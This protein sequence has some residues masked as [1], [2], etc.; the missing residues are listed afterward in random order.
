MKATAKCKG[1]IPSAKI[2]VG[3][4][5]YIVLIDFM[6]NKARVWLFRLKSN[7]LIIGS[8]KFESFGYEAISNENSP[9]VITFC[10]SIGINARVKNNKKNSCTWFIADQK[11]EVDVEFKIFIKAI[12]AKVDHII[13]IVVFWFL[14]NS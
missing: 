3:N 1:I 10:I 9:P 7:L 6:F 13:D 2:I 5:L 14:Q 4:K 12:I 8:I 11:L